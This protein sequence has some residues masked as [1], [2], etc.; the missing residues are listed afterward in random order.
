MDID[1]EK[2]FLRNDFNPN[3]PVVVGVSGGADSVFL[4]D[5]L[6][7]SGIKVIVAHF[8]HQLR[9]ESAQEALFV[10]SIT[11]NY[12]CPF[13]LGTEDVA[14]FSQKNGFSIEEAARICRYRFLFICAENSQAQAVL[15]AHHANDQVETMLMHFLRGSGLDGLKGIEEKVI[16]PEF[17]AKI[18][19]FRPILHIWRDEILTYCQERGLAYVS[20]PTNQETTYFRNQLR[21]ELIPQL[22]VMYPGFVKR[23]LQL[24]DL[25]QGDAEILEELIEQKWKN[26]C[27]EEHKF[28]LVF[29][30]DKFEKEKIGIQRRMIRKALCFLQPNIRDISY[31]VI[32]RAIDAVEEKHLGE[33]ELISNHSLRIG[34][35][36][37]YIYEKNSAWYI[38]LYPQVFSEIVIEQPGEVQICEQWKLV[39]QETDGDDFAEMR[40][41]TNTVY[42]TKD[43]ECIFPWKIK[44][45]TPGLRFRPFG[46]KSGQMKI[47]DFFINEKILS[48]ARKNYPI[49]FDKNN[50]VIWV[51]G[52]RMDERYRVDPFTR[53]FYKL[54]LKKI[55]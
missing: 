47:S 1:F 46:M 40:G 4:L 43:D 27:L 26:I 19:I 55:N 44:N 22:E 52:L 39:I 12:G 41:D 23:S 3:L 51:I 18:P 5:Q 32:N 14:A 10:E 38:D 25:I 36:Q 6:I 17:H 49:L 37:F 54:E 16:L 34:H 8:N 13:L 15:V 33:T 48:P 30:L 42:I 45:Y 2:T 53:S 9:L 21:L 20:D 11:R 35:N 50:R 7:R 28:Y 31:S 29:D 24:T